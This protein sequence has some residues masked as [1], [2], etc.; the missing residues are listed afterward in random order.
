MGYLMNKP[1]D[2]LSKVHG[3]KHDVNL[4]KVDKKKALNV[5][6]KSQEAIGNKTYHAVKGKHDK[7]VAETVSHH[8][9]I[10]LLVKPIDL[11][12]TYPT[13]NLVEIRHV[14][15]LK[16]LKRDLTKHLSRG[17][18]PHFTEYDLS[19][20][21]LSK[22]VQVIGNVYVPIKR[23]E[24]LDIQSTLL[25]ASPELGIKNSQAITFIIVEDEIWDEVIPALHLHSATILALPET[26]HEKVEKKA[27]KTA[28]PVSASRGRDV[29]VTRG[30]VENLTPKMKAQVVKLLLDL[31]AQEF[32]S[33]AKAEK[34]R[35]QEKLKEEKCIKFAI[36][37]YERLQ[38][39][40]L[41][42]SKN[43]ELSSD[44]FES[45][46]RKWEDSSPP[47]P[48]RQVRN[49]TLWRE[50]KSKMVQGYSF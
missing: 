36:E 44:A 5:K 45:I 16:G 29:R 2:S 1:I 30:R 31:I 40:V 15:E 22:K 42:E 35:E 39:L 20:F 37:Q 28:I 14:N 17:N 4:K 27:E 43:K 49:S 18:V 3:I 12:E 7:K 26:L 11:W 41:T 21:G 50:L 9:N 48:I 23:S 38:K 33:K 34:K 10:E 6:V 24:H 19:P 25:R 13:I 32:Y 47:F 46:V 8:V